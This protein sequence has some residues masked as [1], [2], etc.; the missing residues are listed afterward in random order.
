[1]WYRIAPSIQTTAMTQL[2]SANLRLPRKVMNTAKVAKTTEGKI[3]IGLNF[4]IDELT[5]YADILTS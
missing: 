4:L 1:M 2:V 3:I 5:V